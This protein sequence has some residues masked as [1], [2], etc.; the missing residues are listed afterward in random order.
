MRY[1]SGLTLVSTTA[2]LAAGCTG[3]AFSGPESNAGDVSPAASLSP[4]RNLEVILRPA[5]GAEGFGLIKF[6]QPKD[7]EAIVY[8]DIW[9]RDLA[10]NTSYQLQRAVDTNIDDTCTSTAWLT[11]GTG[12]VAQAITTDERG[13]GREAL[14]RNLTSAPGTAFDIY[15]RVIDPTTG[16]VVLQSACYQFE[17]GF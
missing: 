17:V 15:F 13:T 2:L 16:A 5:E 6:R 8:L 10:P 4:N 3:D 1:A 12:T 14:F 7:D 11:L 9:L